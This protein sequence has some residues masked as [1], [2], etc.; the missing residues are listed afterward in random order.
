MGQQRQTVVSQF[1]QL[2]RLVVEGGKSGK[3]TG[4]DGSIIRQKIQ[5]YVL[6]TSMAPDYTDSNADGTEQLSQC[7]DCIKSVYR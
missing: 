6:L 4:N 5:G 2:D 7:F 3:Q 1:F